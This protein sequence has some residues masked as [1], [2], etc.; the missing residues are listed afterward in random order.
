M[1]LSASEQLAVG[2]VNGLISIHSTSFMLVFVL[3][4]FNTRPR[5]SLHEGLMVKNT[6]KEWKKDRKDKKGKKPVVLEVKIAVV[7]QSTT[8]M[9]MR[10][11]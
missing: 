4:S 1:I 3:F 6:V 10:A 11:K 2:V 5:H 7:Q 9:P 8:K